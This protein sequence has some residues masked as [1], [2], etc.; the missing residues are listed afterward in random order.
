MAYI[1]LLARIVDEE[2]SPPEGSFVALSIRPGNEA[3][4]NGI[5]VRDAPKSDS[6]RCS[7][8]YNTPPKS[9]TATNPAAPRTRR[10]PAPPVYHRAFQISGK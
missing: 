9:T 4:S 7:L 6:V 8:V 10:S 5:F 1:T 3:V 2:M